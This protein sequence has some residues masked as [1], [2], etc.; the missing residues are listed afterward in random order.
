MSQRPSTHEY[1]PLRGFRPKEWARGNSR[2][3]TLL[4][5]RCLHV[6]IRETLKKELQ[7]FDSIHF[8]AWI[9]EY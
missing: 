7:S 9:P 8:V 6:R 2:G 5:L 4:L 1:K 3:L